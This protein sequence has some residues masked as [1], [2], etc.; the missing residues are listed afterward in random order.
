MDDKTGGRVKNFLAK[1]LGDGMR[2]YI[3]EIM[4]Q[5]AERTLVECFLKRLR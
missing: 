5:R 3:G 1:V 4:L 2:Y